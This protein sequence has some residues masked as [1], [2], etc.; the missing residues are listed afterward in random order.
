MAIVEVLDALPQEYAK[1]QELIDILD[2]VL[3]QVVRCQDKKSGVWYDVLDVQ[4]PRNY[5][6]STCSSMFAYCL[7]KAARLGYV[8]DDMRQAGIKAYKG[9]LDR[10]IRVNADETISLTD[11]CEVSGLGPAD[12][13]HR[14]GSFDYYM[15]E[16]IRDNDAK[17]IG[18]F[19]WASIEME[20][21]EG[22][23]H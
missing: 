21:L 17:G 1:R 16:P 7:L 6:E 4:D 18:P 5:L 2:R 13:P 23:G 8:G 15:S 22:D 14:D 10:F 11:C 19:I 20:M 9:I 12:K 3:T